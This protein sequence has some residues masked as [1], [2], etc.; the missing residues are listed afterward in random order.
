M[1]HLAD[2]PSVRAAILGRKALELAMRE[3]GVA[4]EM[5][6]ARRLATRLPAPPHGGPKVL[7]LTPRDW[8]VHV[9]IE[10]MLAQALRLRGADVSFLTCGGGLEICD[11]VNTYEGPPVPCH[12]CSG[13][14]R[15]ALTSHDLPFSTLFDGETTDD[16]PELDQLAI[17]ELRDVESD[18]VPLGRL[19]WIPALWFLC[20]SDV[21]HDP[22]AGIT[23]R[24]FLRAGRR[25]QTALTRMLDRAEPDAIV[26]LN[27]LFLFEAIASELA[28]QRGIPVL[29][30]ERGFID[31]TLF[32]SDGEPACRYDVSASWS[33]ARSRSLTTVENERLDRYL[34][35]RRLGLRS[36]VQMWP[37][38]RFEVSAG[39]PRTRTRLALFTNVTWDSAAQDRACAFADI[40]EWLT[41]TVEQVGGRSDVELVIRIHP[42]EIRIRGWETREP[43]AAFLRQ[44]FPAMPNNVRVIA[45]DDDLSSYSLME[46]A[47]A[48]LVFTSTSGLEL[49]LFGKPVIVAGLTHYRGKGFTVDADSHESH[50]TALDAIIRDPASARPDVELA[51]RYANLFFFDAVEQQPPV[52]EPI[53]GLARLTTTDPNDLLPGS[54]GGIDAV[55]DRIF[56]LVKGRH[57]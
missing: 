35:D 50:R 15:R 23:L 55:C 45:P 43:V 20:S 24:R 2:R 49:A 22:A 16:W 12:T 32:F 30:Y 14:V 3:V 41:N 25:I 7:F 47:D 42:A 46:S 10:A 27:G 17:R 26:L 44:R 39:H 56:Q 51:R 21:E 52:A 13:Y 31:G 57:V 38:P 1:G 18:G 33:R 5:R 11:R 19:V 9:Q 6:Q 48:G 37:R 8:V 29:S 53:G 28:R 40:R 54:H 36:F 34:A 4:P